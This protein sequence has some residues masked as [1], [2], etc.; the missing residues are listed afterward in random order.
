MMA[1]EE[2]DKANEAARASAEVQKEAKRRLQECRKQKEAFRPDIEEGYFFTAPR[3]ARDISTDRIRNNDPGSR[4][5]TDAD[6]LQISIGMEEAENFATTL[7]Q[8]FMPDGLN[9][10]EQTVPASMREEF[11]PET[12]ERGKAQTETIFSLLRESNFDAELASSLNPDAAIGTHALQIL[13]PGAAK[14]VMCRAVP[15]RELEIDVGPDGSVGTRFLVRQH[16]GRDVPAVLKDCTGAG[17]EKIL[18]KCKKRE[19]ADFLVRWGWWRLHDR[20]DDVWWQYVVMV[21]DDVC[22]EAQLKGEGSCE[23]VVARF[24]PHS[25]F[26]FGEGPAIRALPEL[27]H[28][29]DMA[30]AETENV[31]LTLR[32]PMTYPDDSFANIENGV[33]PGMFYP[34]RPGTEGAVRKMFEP[35]PLDAALFDMQNRERRVRRLFYNDMPEQRGDTPPTATQWVDEMAMAQRKIGTPG[36]KYWRE[37]PL[38]FFKRFRYIAAARGLI[39]MDMDRPLVPR[40]P[41]QRAQDMQKASNAL[42]GGQAAAA[43]FPEEFKLAVDGG[44]TIPKLLK[45]F[46]ADGVIVMRSENDIKNAA[47]LIA[48]VQGGQP[49]DAGGAALPGMPG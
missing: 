27:R 13:D 46:D 20:V 40:N 23:L 47:G 37:G 45:L 14:P 39:V 4:V 11:K 26:A 12:E 8:S 15:L 28:L 1:R 48:Q 36:K 34:I 22:H 16:K 5:E 35:N 32:A 18:S 30:G 42:R 21:D 2:Q 41:A 7:I 29:D 17:K 43:I 31:D 9:W 6:L 33:E 38:E 3:R 19:N 24:N 25:E 10:I 44:K 49:I